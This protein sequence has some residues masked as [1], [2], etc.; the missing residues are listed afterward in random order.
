MLNGLAVSRGADARG[1]ARATESWRRQGFA[2]TLHWR[3]DEGTVSGFTHESRS[4]DG[5]APDNASVRTSDGFA[6]CAGPL[7]YRRRFGEAAL[8]ALLDD[9][10]LSTHDPLAGIDAA[11]LRGNFAAFI[12][13]GGSAWLLND[14]LGLQ[15]IY[16][17]DDGCYFGTSW[18]ATRAYAGDRAIDEAAAI[19]YV[20]LG[21]SH[22]DRTVARRVGK[23]PLGHRVDLSAGRIAAGLSARDWEFAPETAFGPGRS[24]R[25]ID[26]AVEA[27]VAHLR[28]VF[29]EIAAAF[30]GRVNA[31]LSGGF[32]SRLVVAAL[33]AV[34]ERPNLFVYGSDDAVDVSIAR[35][36]AQ[37]EALALRAIDK[38]VLDRG[39]DPLDLDGLVQS[40]QFFD[41]LP[42]DGIDDPGS[43][44]DTRL[45][46]NADG[47]IAV[48]GGGGEIFRNFFHL[49]DRR[50]A[51]RDVV[52]VFYRGFDAA[53]FRRRHALAE[54]ESRLAQAIA[55]SLGSTASSGAMTA[56]ADPT[57]T[58]SRR[59][60]ELVYPLFRCHH[61]M[62]LNNT[63]LTRH[64]AFCT[65]LVNLESARIAASLPLGWKNAGELESR[66]IA[67]L[68][69]RIAGYSSAYGFRMRD[70]PN[71]RARAGEWTTCSR[72]AWSR[73]LINT[74]HRKLGGRDRNLAAVL[75]RYRRL[76]GGE[77]HLDPLLDLDRLSD[78]G[79]LARALA[80]EVTS[81]A[82]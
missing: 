31:A 37:A 24:L 10:E 74:L 25:T 19:E 22:S 66:L 69:P 45:A 49:P 13:K 11:S 65:P 14:P 67:A 59:E 57:R 80:V 32:D 20:L 2:P 81:R 1:L 62:A 26:E 43:D 3:F 5:Q 7:W 79:A 46:Q 77:W 34:G 35:Q 39:R 16:C 54:Y 72:P 8:G 76:L 64:G 29:V 73:P 28:I 12:G 70:G 18:L 4:V 48:N 33:V 63:A 21:A 41:G 58:L 38:R 71:L 61:W 53:V 56:A 40:A 42:N 44:R 6:C 78:A 52:R 30:P 82:L 47:R 75:Q 9:I 23:L 50:Y 17:A 15:Q 36:V 55:R 27:L 68:H 51:T 60:V